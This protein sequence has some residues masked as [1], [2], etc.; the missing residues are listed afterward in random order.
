[1]EYDYYGKLLHNKLTCIERR[2]K[3]RIWDDGSQDVPLAEAPQF[4]GPFGYDAVLRIA[5]RL[6]I[7]DKPIVQ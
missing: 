7:N 2:N 6:S 1:M 5:T 4:I 3:P